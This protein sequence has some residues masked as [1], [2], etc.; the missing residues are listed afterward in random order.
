MRAI[1]RSAIATPQQRRLNS[2]FIVAQ[3]GLTLLVLVSAGLLVRSM[4]RLVT[5]EKGFATENLAVFRVAL[6]QSNYSEY[7]KRIQFYDQLLGKLRA[8]PGVESAASGDSIPLRAGSN[9]YFS[10]AGTTW[11]KG[12]EPLADKF[13]VSPEFHRTFGITLLK[14]RDF[15]PALDKLPANPGG[16]VSASVI[17]NQ[18]FA[19]KYFPGKDPVGQRVAWGSDSA[20]AQA[21]YTWDVVVGVVSDARMVSLDRAVNPAMYASHHQSPASAQYVAVRSRLDPAA[22]LPALR[23]QLRSLD[24]ELPLTTLR[25]MRF[26]VDD[27]LAQRKLI[28]W[29][30]GAAAS[31]SLLLAVLGLYSVVAYTVAQQTREIGVRM[32]LGAAP[33]N[34]R[35]WVLKRGVVLVALGIFAGI[36]CSMVVSRL[37]GSLVYDVSAWDPVTYGAV[38]LLLG[39]TALLACRIP[40]RRAASIDPL[41]ALRSE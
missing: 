17:I 16:P 38:A 26:Y 37:L 18:A 7:P 22:I 33:G 23:E 28:T 34:I 39:L 20:N 27:A 10:V 19:D 9:G 30:V 24:P 40:A 12:Q 31:T 4:W 29:T 11:V 1:G 15:D 2:I 3:V 36:A 13:V 32:A 25:T 41:V 21:G 6:P 8:L 14:G 35:D 5:Q